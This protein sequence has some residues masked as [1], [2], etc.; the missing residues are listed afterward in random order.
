MKK[1]R[2]L[3]GFASLALALCIGANAKFE[4][5]TT[6][7]ENTFTDIPATA[8][9]AGEVK[10]TYELG[11][12]QGTSDT[13]FA[14]EDNVTLA[15]AITVASR[16]SALYNG[17]EIPSAEGAWYK[18]YV[19]YATSKGFFA[20]KDGEDY[21]RPATRME[22]ATI[23]ADA[24][25]ESYFTPKNDVDFIPDVLGMAGYDKLLKLYRA[26]VVLG[27]DDI[28]SFYP[29]KNIKRAEMSAIINRVALPENRLDGD[30]ALK[31]STDDAYVLALN[32]EYDA[33]KS[34][35]SL[36]L[37]LTSGWLLDNRGGERR[38]AYDGK[39]EILKD[40][41]TTEGVALIREFNKTTTGYINF[42][43]FFA[44]DNNDGLYLEAR[45]DK[46][47][48][49]YHLEIKDGK[50][51]YKNK[52]GSFTPVY[53]IDM[54]KGTYYFRVEIDLDNKYSKTYINN[55]CYAV[56][57][58]TADDVNL[59]NFR[60]AYT[61][62]GTGTTDLGTFFAY[63]NY[64]MYDDFVMAQNKEIP[65][66][67][68]CD[69]A[70]ASYT[71]ANKGIFVIQ[72][73][74][75]AQRTFKRTG[76]KAVFEY[77]FLQTI[78]E[79]LE[80]VLYGEGK[81]VL[82][83]TNDEKK[84]YFNGKEFY[85]DYV[86]DM[87]YRIRVELDFNTHK[88]VLKLNSR[89][90][91]DIEIP[92]DVKC[93][94]SVSFAAT[95]KNGISLDEI[96][97]YN[98]YE[99]E[100]YVPAP[101][102]LPNAD[103]YIVG[104]NVCSLWRSDDRHRSWGCITPYSD[105]QP[106]LG[107]YDEGNIETA[108]WENKFMAEHGI[109]FQAFCWYPDKNNGPL[110]LNLPYHIQDAYMNSKYA[111]IVKYAIQWEA[112]G[113]SP[114]SVD[115]F[116]KYYGSYLVENYFKDKDRYMTIDNQP[117]LI[118][119]S[120]KN[121]MD[122]MGG[123]AKVKECIDWLENECIKLGYDGL[124][125]FGSGSVPDDMADTGVDA[126]YPYNWSYA[127]Y[128]P[129]HN[130]AM[131]IQKQEASNIYNIPTVSVGFN[132]IGWEDI[133]HPIMTEEGFLETLNWIKD[134]YIPKY[135]DDGWQKKMVML[136]TWNEY[137]EG[138]YI[139]PCEGNNGFGYLDSLKK[140]LFGGDKSTCNDVVPTEAQK[141]R[142]NRLYP[143]YR[144][145]LR[146]E[147]FYE[148][149]VN[150]EFFTK[151]GEIDYSKKTDKFSNPAKIDNP[152]WTNKGL[153]G[154]CA[155]DAQVYYTF[156]ENQMKL[157]DIGT[158]KIT[159]TFPKS[160]SIMMFY[161]SGND[162]S[163][164]SKKS[165]KFSSNP[166]GTRDTY[167]VD[168]TNLGEDWTGLL[169]KFRIDPATRVGDEFCVEKIE[170]LSA[171]TYKS[172]YVDD[173]EISMQY[174][175]QKEADGTVTVG[176]DPYNGME[177]A[178]NAFSI[179]DRDAQKLTL[180]FE[181]D[182]TFVFT[183]GSNK[184]TFNGSEKTLGF[185]VRNVDGLPYIP[186]KVVC[187]AIGYEFS[188]N[189]GNSIV[190]DT[191]YEPP[192]YEPA[193]E[194]TKLD[195]FT[196]S[197][198][199]ESN[200]F[201][202]VT[203]M[204]DTSNPEK[205]YE[206]MRVMPKDDASVYLY[207]MNKFTFVP[208]ATYKVYADLRLVSHGL[209]TMPLPSGIEGKLV[210]NMRYKD[211]N[212]TDHVIT[213]Y[214]LGKSMDWTHVE[215][216]FTIPASAIDRSADYFTIYSEPRQGRAVGY[217]LR[218]VYIADANDPTN[219]EFEAKLQAERDAEA[220]KNT[221]NLTY[222]S[223]STT[224]GTGKTYDDAS[225]VLA[226]EGTPA[227]CY[228]AIP[229]D[230]ET[231]ILYTNHAFKF[232]AGETYKVTLDFRLNPTK[233]GRATK[234]STSFNMQYYE[235]SSIN[236][237]VYSISQSSDDGWKSHEFFFTVSEASAIRSNDKFSLFSNP[238]DGIAIGYSLRNVVV[239]RAS[240]EEKAAWEEKK[241][242]GKKEES[243]P[244]EQPKP[245]TPA[246]TTS[247][248]EKGP[249]KLDELFTVSTAVGTEKKYEEDGKKVVEAVPNAGQSNIL[250]T[251][252]KTAF[253]PG[254]TYKL[255]LEVKGTKN[256][257]GADYQNASLILN[258]MYTDPDAN[259]GK[260]H[261][262][263]TVKISSNGAWTPVE[264]EFTVPESCTDR[265]ND[266]VSM[267]SSAV[268][269]I[270]SGY[271]VR[272]AVLTLVNA[273]DVKVEEKKEETT[274][275][276]SVSSI[277]TFDQS[278][279]PEAIGGDYVKFSVS[280]GGGY[281]M[282]AVDPDDKN[283]YCYLAVPHK[284]DPTYLYTYHNY[285]FEAGAEY[286]VSCDVRLASKG[287]DFNTTDKDFAGK[288]CFNMQYNDTEKNTVNHVVHSK[289]VKISDGWVHVTYSFKVSENATDRSKDKFSMYLDKGKV[290]GGAYYVDNLVITKK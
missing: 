168:T 287:H 243:K 38:Y 97:A 179:W 177:L 164:T 146:Y 98:V 110:Q 151:Y 68:D 60:F 268:D 181:N 75:K 258:M 194:R 125:V 120:Y 244:A 131:M 135:A 39:Y 57:P 201:K 215:F 264:I 117:V 133:R 56:L 21:N 193:C 236:H 152:Q 106:V 260:N 225:G 61:D 136:S 199:Y 8:W 222:F 217:D 155:G 278:K 36:M 6:F 234:T 269:G 171:S 256:A 224:T 108:D 14:P 2:R 176:Y 265:K 187:D 279:I 255:T 142:I 180:C 175:Y 69:K 167:F 25:P 150:E 221:W 86:H 19:D 66:F 129:D 7:P 141:E 266:S 213:G 42:M 59:Y 159:G 259:G 128:S 11:L 3:L 185:K 223:P 198:S 250:Y 189:K 18:M 30:I 10:N 137:G 149:E 273:S 188:I 55:E 160:D 4:K 130:K 147:A 37:P 71:N 178:L 88:G 20:E 216:E 113:S 209:S 64:A 102:V 22:V 140:S 170:F 74:G 277:P 245:A 192:V 111:G 183:V 267:Y 72:D 247:A 202:A 122:G 126:R 80:T 220:I 51:Q 26:G 283:N 248:N 156:T 115:A 100:D 229:N 153:S 114:A 186:L 240:K 92:A 54:T 1:F 63:A 5:T 276:T 226:A 232:D 103:D 235:P 163:F 208:G 76:D 85:S 218:N 148:E 212:T 93:M 169:F 27:N 47:E 52:D 121:L 214:P 90:I 40:V 281:G 290:S 270:S 44:C 286:E 241:N 227:P 288:L 211:F 242:A 123:K 94:D 145:V 271:A 139:M 154:V 197:T 210:F 246:P 95:G 162:S 104:I 34:G 252:A 35:K 182:N 83:I 53:D 17:E 118:I 289:D 50:W 28:G 204:T 231:R 254:G 257:N 138:T 23:F 46:D 157:E 91:M 205:P 282:R 190:I 132:K 78:G 233:D 112:S 127:G 45:N 87:W 134:E 29:N 15:Q 272:N 12:M 239:T 89:K 261:S 207:S 228:D 230:G 200:G 285:S 31:K 158:V 184:Y 206:F 116:K 172:L 263:K 41:S 16:V 119:Y 73:G 166:E 107:Y 32:L 101:T 65:L 165:I 77:N 81:K 274:T 280:N 105:K 9:Y 49:I 13:Q 96:R 161:M 237:V 84:F 219:A 195:N 24:L 109:D 251:T 174:A 58:L 144:R 124:L 143:Q 284:P 48:A 79:K 62:E 249:W 70:A 196:G 99:K 43:T 67:W 191:G 203:K 173:H 275:T 262:L 33:N 82:T 253:V 238:A